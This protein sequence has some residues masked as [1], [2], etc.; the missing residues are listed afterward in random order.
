MPATCDGGVFRSKRFSEVEYEE[1]EFASI[2]HLW[3]KLRYSCA[4]LVARS[5]LCNMHPGNLPH[6]LEP[7]SLNLPPQSVHLLLFVAA[8]TTFS[9]QPAVACLAMH[10]R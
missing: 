6:L 1:G 9:C 3:V 5:Q 7:A 4:L 2:G 10:I 8:N